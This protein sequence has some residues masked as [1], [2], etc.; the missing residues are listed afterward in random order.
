MPARNIIVP[1]FTVL[2]LS[3]VILSYSRT[4]EDWRGAVRYIAATTRPGDSVWFSRPYGA[5][6]YDYY[7]RR[8]T[9]NDL[10]PVIVVDKDAARR[11]NGRMWVM[12]YPP[13]TP[14]VQE[15]QLEL[16]AGYTLQPQPAFRGLRLLL[17]TPKR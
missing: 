13:N 1:F 3:A 11:T 7:A 9:S 16:S 8:M 15:I 4:R 14:D 12:I 17:A 10:E 6:P 5:I 2:S